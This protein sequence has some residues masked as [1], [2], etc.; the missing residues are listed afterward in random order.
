MM[1]LKLFVLFLLLVPAAIVQAQSSDSGS[2]V[3]PTLKALGD[4]GW[5]TTLPPFAGF[6]PESSFVEIW[7]PPGN[8][9]APV[10]VYAHG[11]AGFRKD[12]LARVEMFRRQGYATIS[13]D[14][15]E[16]NGFDDWNFVT[17]RVINGGKQNM[18][19]GVYKG[20][21]EYAAQDSRWDKR[22][23]FLYGASNGARVALHAASEFV[24]FQIRGVIAE[25]P[26]A[27][28]YPLGDIK[29]PT[30]IVFGKLDN[31]AGRSETDYIWKRTYPN[32]PVSLEKTVE[33][34][35]KNGRPV[36]FLFYDNAGH[37]F[38]E[39]PLRKV[40]RGRASGRTFSAHEGAD[41][42]TLRQYERDVL[43][44]VHNNKSP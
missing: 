39:G 2:A 6:N 31:W 35:Q 42:D 18:I 7:T 44:F 11:G 12:D 36:R 13:F 22:N 29:I 28:G 5:F 4:S 8:E 1:N 40:S 25:A 23:I 34:L 3:E 9:R 43:E 32:S 37:S 33:A 26:A 38:H 24:D 21:I 27:N 14:S 16:M 10:V 17:R 15:Y 41:E 20:A 19:W 30:I